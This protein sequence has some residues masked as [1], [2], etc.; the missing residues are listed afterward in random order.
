MIFTETSLPGAYI[1]ELDTICDERGFFART[2]CA[3][4]FAK[5]GLNTNLVQ[6]NISFNAY[7]GTLRGM[8]YQISP[9]EEAKVV[10]CIAGSIY[11]VILDLRA[12]SPTFRRWQAFELSAS[13]RRMLYIPEGCAHGFQT[14]QDDTTVFYQMSEFY[15]PE[16]SR[17]MRWDDSAFSIEWPVSSL[18]ISEKDRGYSEIYFR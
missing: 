16:Y 8:H 18:I 3:K 2:W 9:H 17:G 10:S 5:H 11:D 4:E 12:D 1:I 14:L 6:C 13:N 15:H 7:R